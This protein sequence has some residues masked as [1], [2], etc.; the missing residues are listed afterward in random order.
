MPRKI[1]YY[2]VRGYTFQNGTRI[3]GEWSAPAKY[4][5]TIAK[6]AAPAVK[7]ASAKT[8]KLTWKKVANA[9]K[10]EIWTSTKKTSGYKR[11]KVTGNVSSATL[12]ATKGKTVYYKIR[13]YTVVSGKRVNSLFSSPK[14][15]KL[16]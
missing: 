9:T 13:G 16:K 5:V 1:G 3:N 15:Y 10:Y 7:K 6:P 4:S 8:V 11:V 2:R 12:S 14:A